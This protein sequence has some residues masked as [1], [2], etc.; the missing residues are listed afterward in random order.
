MA[1]A[2]A[3]WTYRAQCSFSF[4]VIFCN[5][6]VYT[7]ASDILDTGAAAVNDLEG[8]SAVK[9]AYAS[10]GFNSNQVPAKMITGKLG[11]C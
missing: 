11:C 10:K 1:A 5:L 6:A 4:L 8:C 7:L 2:S 9:S 3:T